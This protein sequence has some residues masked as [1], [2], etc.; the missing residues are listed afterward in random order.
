M[1][2]CALTGISRWMCKSASPVS[3]PS[4][5]RDLSHVFTLLRVEKQSWGDKFVIWEEFIRPWNRKIG[6]TGYHK[7]QKNSS[8]TTLGG[9]RPHHPPTLWIRHCVLLLKQLLPDICQAEATSTF[10][11][12]TRAQEHWAAATYC[13][14]RDFT[15]DVWSPNRPY[16]SSVVYRIWNAFFRNNKGRQTSSMNC[17]Y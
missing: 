6:K 16:R 3:R 4:L 14:T 8:E 1:T 13:K 10:Q 2:A 9:D 15:S 7:W 11:R 12:T 5:I 17:G